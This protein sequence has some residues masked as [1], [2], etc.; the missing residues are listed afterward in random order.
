MIS[1]VKIWDTAVEGDSSEQWTSVSTI[2]F[3]EPVTAINLAPS[4][5]DSEAVHLAAG[6]ESGALFVYSSTT[7]D[8]SNWTLA[9]TF[10]SS[11][12]PDLTITEL[13]LNPAKTGPF[14]LAV[15]SADGSLRVFTVEF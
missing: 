7:G 2:K 8:L 12:F 3:E 1:K 9:Y 5:P 10:P 14:E 15:S 4:A 6:T 13:E 11:L